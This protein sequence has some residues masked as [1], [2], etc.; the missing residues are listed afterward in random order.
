LLTNVIIGAYGPK[1]QGVSLTK[2]NFTHLMSQNYIIKSFG[3]GNR[4]IASQT[5]SKMKSMLKIKNKKLG[6]LIKPFTEEHTGQ[7]NIRH[8]KVFLFV[9]FILPPYEIEN[10]IDYLDKD[11]DGFVSN[12][13]IEKELEFAKGLL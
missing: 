13:D 9:T 7:I 3:Q 6:E 12:Q 2:D 10:M 8:L 1:P 4:T 11:N 5:F